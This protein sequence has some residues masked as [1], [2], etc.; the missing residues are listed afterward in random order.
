MS[1][2]QGARFSAA[3]SDAVAGAPLLLAAL[4]AATDPVHVVVD[5]GPGPGKLEITA[6]VVGIPL[7]PGRRAGG[8]ARC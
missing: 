8:L 3:K 2:R 6:A 4:G 1:I 7:L 5:H